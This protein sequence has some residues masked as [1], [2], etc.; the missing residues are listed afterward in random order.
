MAAQHQNFNLQ[1]QPQ[2]VNK[3]NVSIYKVAPQ[4]QAV[5]GSDLS[6]SKV[7]Y[8]N[9]LVSR[10]LDPDLY[11]AQVI[12][13]VF[14]ETS[15]LDPHT[16]WLQTQ[17]RLATPLSCDLETKITKPT[18]RKIYVSSDLGPDISS[19][20]DSGGLIAWVFRGPFLL[21]SSFHD[22]EKVD[23]GRKNEQ[24]TVAMYVGISKLYII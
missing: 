7:N 16:S 22:F 17:T 24:S 21:N 23:K 10:D 13:W 18:S 14:D 11:P 3:Y 15:N 9:I 6:L 20:L 2:A 8:Q 19:G 4:H 1:M 12:D 5:P